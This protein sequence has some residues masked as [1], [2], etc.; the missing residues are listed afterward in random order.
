MAKFPLDALSVFK[1]QLLEFLVVQSGFLSPLGEIWDKFPSAI[2]SYF[3]ERSSSED[4]IFC[5][6]A[7]CQ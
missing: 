2:P 3:I 6:T 5:S 7:Q 1:L 4:K